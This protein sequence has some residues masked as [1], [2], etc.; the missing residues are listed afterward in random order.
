M[1]SKGHYNDAINILRLD[2]KVFEHKYASFA[3]GL[4]LET[5]ATVENWYSI[6]VWARR[7]IAYNNFQVYTQDKLIN[8]ILLS[9]NTRAEQQLQKINE[10]SG[11]RTK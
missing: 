10:N 6:E 1:I 9:R 3:I 8:M 2:Y 4:M 5:M 7:M 11:R